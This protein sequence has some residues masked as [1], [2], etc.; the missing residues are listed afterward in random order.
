M[1]FFSIVDD[2][3]VDSEVSMVA[4]SISRICRLSL[5]EI[6]IGV[7]YMCACERLYLYFF[8]EKMNDDTG[9]YQR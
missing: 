7:G 3:L 2:M 9:H 5:S 1:F 4:S 8:S 6:L